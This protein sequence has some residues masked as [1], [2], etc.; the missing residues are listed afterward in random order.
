MQ[1]TPQLKEYQPTQMR[2]IQHK[3]SGNSGTQSFLLPN[4][5]TISSAMI[6]QSE[7]V[8]M[9]DRI[10]NLDGSKKFWDSGES[11]NSIQEF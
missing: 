6:N 2:N 1:M 9:T 4:D 10:Q 8:E 3:N 7:M 11:D 5:H